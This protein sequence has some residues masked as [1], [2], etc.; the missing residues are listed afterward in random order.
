MERSR[1]QT[2]HL[3]KNEDISLTDEQLVVVSALFSFPDQVVT[4][5]YFNR[6]QKLLAYKLLS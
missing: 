6:C 5:N 4:I 2:A 1:E 3:L